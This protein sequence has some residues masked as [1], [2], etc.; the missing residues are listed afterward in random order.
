MALDVEKQHVT[1]DEALG[2]LCQLPEVP[3]LLVLRPC[4]EILGN[5]YVFCFAGTI[6]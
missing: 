2:A 6:G 5:V 1:S 3:V 4:C